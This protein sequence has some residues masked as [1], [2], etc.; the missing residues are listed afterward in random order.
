[1]SERRFQFLQRCDRFNDVRG[2]EQR[3]KLNKMTTH[4]SGGFL[5]IL[6]ITVKD[7]TLFPNMYLLTKNNQRFEVF[8][9]LECIFPTSK[10]P[11]I[12][13]KYLL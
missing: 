10:Q 8:V 1:M 12:S 6:L 3:I 4:I 13:L 11:N 9:T 5:N 2:R 7:Y